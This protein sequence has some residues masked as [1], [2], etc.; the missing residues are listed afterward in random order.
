MHL[1]VD[2]TGLQ[3]CGPSEWVVE[4]HDTCRRRSWRKLHIGVD[5]GQILASE[6]TLYEVA[7]G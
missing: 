2:S 7:A 1:L 5:T 6:L 4:K 3:L